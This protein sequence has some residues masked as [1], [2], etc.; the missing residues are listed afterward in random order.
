MTHNFDARMRIEIH[1]EHISV[2]VYDKTSSQPILL[3]GDDGRTA[4]P[5]CVSFVGEAPFTGQS[6]VNKM[7]CKPGKYVQ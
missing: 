3:K 4:T 2:A 5:I 7:K 1:D 6:A